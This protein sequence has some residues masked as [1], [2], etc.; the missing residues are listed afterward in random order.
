MLENIYESK[1]V[2]IEMDK[3]N[4]LL[5]II[6]IGHT[7]NLTDEIY[8]KEVLN[9]VNTVKKYQPK[10]VLDDARLFNMPIVP[11]TQ[12][13]VALTAVDVYSEIIEKYAMVM[14][15]EIFAKVSAEQNINE[16]KRIGNTT[17]SKQFDSVE[18]AKKWLEI[19]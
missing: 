7:E 16:V 19:E 6:W 9:I 17:E 5:Y 1:F 15:K 10:I 11:E 4:F 13:W 3:D 2:T 18:E 12:E 14:P 8:R